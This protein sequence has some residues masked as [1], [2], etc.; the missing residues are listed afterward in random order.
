M[1]FYKIKDDLRAKKYDQLP[2]EELNALAISK[3]PEDMQRIVNSLQRMMMKLICSMTK[4]SVTSND[5]LMQMWSAAQ[6]GIAIALSKY[7]KDDVDFALYAWT[8]SRNTIVSYMITE[9]HTVK[10][11]IINGERMYAPVFSI[12]AANDDDDNDNSFQYEYEEELAEPTINFEAIK[13]E[14][15]K[16]K[17][18]LKERSWDIF[19]DTYGIIDGRKKKLREMSLKYDCT[20]E[21]I[22]LSNFRVMEKLRT[23]EVIYNYLYEQLSK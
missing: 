6:E 21:A 2:A 16:G 23:N 5:D 22:R 1:D 13:E 15:Q 17:H 8:W 3:N 7:E 10:P 9:M 14:L 20:S 18:P 11:R 4:I 12:D 19:S